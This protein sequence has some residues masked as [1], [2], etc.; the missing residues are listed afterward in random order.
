MKLETIFDGWQGYNTSLINAIRPLSAEQLS[1]RP[2]P[3]ANSIGEIIQ[4][5]CAGRI[6]WFVRMD[7]P[8]SAALAEDVIDWI[9]DADGNQHVEDQTLADETNAADLVLWLERTWAMID[10]TL[11]AW[12]VDDLAKTYRHTWNGNTYANSYQW[13]LWRIMSHDIHHG[14]EVSLMLGMQGIEAFEL[15][16]L[17]GHIVSPGVME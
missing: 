8:K 4:H 5:L 11:A 10:A 17:F 13:T 6:T 2:M 16:D 9:E 14:G 15:S 3:D 12:S 7:A 1:F